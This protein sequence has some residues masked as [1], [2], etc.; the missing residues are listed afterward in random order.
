MQIT[1]VP[2]LCSNE[3]QRTGGSFCESCFARFLT[4]KS[5][6][7]LPCFT[8]IEDDGAE[9]QTLVMRR[10]ERQESTLLTDEARER[11]AYGEWKGWVAWVEQAQQA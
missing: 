1:M 4:Q 5:D 10:G 2:G 8:A 11:L 3:Y 6:A 9:L 7:E